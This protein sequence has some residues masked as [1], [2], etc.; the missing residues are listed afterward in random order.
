MLVYAMY[1]LNYCF[2]ASNNYIYIKILFFVFAIKEILS[3]NVGEESKTFTTVV[4]E[5]RKML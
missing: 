2:F 3:K 5:S 4:N 1:F